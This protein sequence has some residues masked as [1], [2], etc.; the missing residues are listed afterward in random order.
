ML[1]EV[2]GPKRGSRISWVSLKSPWVFCK[3]AIRQRCAKA[4]GK[5]FCCSV[6]FFL[7]MCMGVGAA[8]AHICEGASAWVYL[9]R[10]EDNPGDCSSR[11]C[12]LYLRQDLS[13]VWS[14]LVIF[15]MNCL[16][17]TNL[18]LSLHCLD[19]SCIS[20]YLV[21][22]RW[23]RG[24]DLCQLPRPFCLSVCVLSVRNL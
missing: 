13:L 18:P 21:F 16:S 10:S 17:T 3:I 19:P 5:L 8:G 7:L 15:W 9:W 20:P 23:G 12:V 1:W 14:S 22:F 4:R 11:C 2:W 6:F 24:L